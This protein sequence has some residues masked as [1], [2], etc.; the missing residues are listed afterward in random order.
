[1]YT[2]P[3]HPEIVKNTQGSCPLCGMDLVR[4]EKIISSDPDI[5]LESLL[6]PPNEFVISSI[7]LTT[8][9]ERK[10]DIQLE[11]LGQVAYDTKEIGTISSRVGGRIT[12]LY[13]RYKFQRVKKGQKIME[14][15]SPELSTAQ[16]N[17]LFLLKN[18]PGNSTL[19]QAAQD[20]LLL[21][22]V[23]REQINALTK[24]MNP[25]RSITVYSNY[26]G[27]VTDLTTNLANEM[28]GS[29]SQVMTGE[30]GIRE[31]MYLQKGQSAF[32]IYNADRVWVLL[33]L[34]PGQQSL[35]KPGDPINI[36]PEIAPHN[37][38]QGRVDYVEPI[39]RAGAKSV[40]IRVM[41]DNSKM[42]L[43]IGSR[44]RATVFGGMK[45]AFWLPKESILSLGRNNLVF[46]KEG[47]GFV[48]RKIKPGIELKKF[49][50]ILDGISLSDSV[51]M[52]AQFLVDNEAFIQL[53]KNEY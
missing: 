2:C 31:G 42:Q 17:L 29:T 53:K 7:P 52:N 6:K 4:Q 41:V 1:M 30:L 16:Q 22:G 48:A 44:V 19:I 40:T 8:M 5:E 12:R 35:V 46:V 21:L 11:L 15:Y 25:Y 26:S 47:K 32:S 50:Q 39:F 23:T 27:F 18:D 51:V 45:Q 9:V 14:I 49:V 3:M 20:R 28:N 38:F 34:Y 36:I 10:E 24:S 33:S 13:V 37:N 43:P